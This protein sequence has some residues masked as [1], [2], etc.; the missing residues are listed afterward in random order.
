MK[1]IIID[2]YKEFL[3]H[4]EGLEYSNSETIEETIKHNKTPICEERILI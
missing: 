4:F 1:I 2:E 3:S